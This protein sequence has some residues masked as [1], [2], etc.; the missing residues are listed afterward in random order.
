MD[1]F[2]EVGIKE[3]LVGK[4]L[5]RYI[6]YMRTRWKSKEDIQCLT[7]YAGKWAQRF[8]RGYEYGASDLEGQAIL[9][10]IDNE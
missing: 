5:E 2:R 3:G 8:K 10:R 7:G 4:T 1:T 6:L 9:A